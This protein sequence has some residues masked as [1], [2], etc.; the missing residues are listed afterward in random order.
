MTIPTDRRMTRIP[1]PQ[2]RSDIPTDTTHIPSDTQIPTGCLPRQHSDIPIAPTNPPTKIPPHMTK[3]PIDTMTI[4]TEEDNIPTDT[5]IPPDT[6]IPTDIMTTI[7]TD[8]MTLPPTDT[9]SNGLLQQ[10]AQRS[11]ARL[12]SLLSTLSQL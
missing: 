2:Q 5:T 12:V 11:T 10:Y 6:T 3:N 7:P 9:T 4:P 8:M 1:T